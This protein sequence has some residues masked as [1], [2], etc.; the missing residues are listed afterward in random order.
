MRVSIDEAASALG[1]S[2]SSVRRRIKAG[3]LTVERETTPAGFRYAVILPDETSSPAPSTDYAPPMQTPS[4]PEQV[5]TLTTERDWLRQRVEELTTL[6][7]REQEAVL[8]LS[9]QVHSQRLLNDLVTPTQ[10]PSQDASRRRWWQVLV[11]G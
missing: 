8:R 1:L 3:S 4:H 9:S 7:N 10:T 2:V 11:W 5:E 6:L